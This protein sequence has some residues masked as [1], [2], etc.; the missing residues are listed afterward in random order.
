MVIADRLKTKVVTSFSS[1]TISRFLQISLLFW[2]AFFAQIQVK[3][4]I[5]EIEQ[6][7]SEFNNGNYPKAIK[8]AEENIEQAVKTNDDLSV[9]KRLDIIASSQISLGKYEEAEVT[10]NNSLR[11]F[12]EKESISI[13]KA[14]IFIR[15]A[16][17]NR[18]QRK[19]AEAFDYSRKA[20]AAAPNNRQIQA[21]HYLNIGRILFAS[22]YDI[23]AV[24]WLEKAEK[25]FEVEK[26]SSAKLDTYRF[27]TLAWHSKLNY[28]TALKYAEKWILSAQNSRFKYQYRQALFESVMVL[29]ESEQNEKAHLYLE[30]GLKLSEEQNDDYQACKFLTSLLLHSL[31]KG[32]ISVASGYLNKLEKNNFENQFSFEIKLGKAV[33]SA[34]SGEIETSKKLF[35]ELEKQ[36]NTSDFILLYWKI[37]VAEINSDWQ[38]AIKLNRE[39]LKVTEENN[40][41]DGLPKIYLNF[42]RAYYRL[43]KS[44]MS[45]EYLEKSLAYIEEIRKSENP[46]LSLALF[47][48]YHN[49]Y[50]LLAQIKSANPQESFELADF[51]KAR[52][53][54]DKINN[55]ANKTEMVIQPEIRQKLEEL[56]I[57]FIN[58]QSLAGEVE[59]NEKLITSQAAELNLAKPDLSELSKISDLDETAVVSY[60][61]TLDKKLKAFVW[62]KNLPLKSV[63]LTISEAEVESYAVITHQ[64][65]KNFIFFKKDGKEIYDKLLKPLNI[66]AK[67]L[68]IVPDKSL[69]KIPFQALSPDGEKYLIEEKLIS[70]APSVSILLKQIQNPKPNRQSLKAFAN[71]T[72]EN[73][74]LQYA[75]AEATGVA[76]I[77]GSNPLLNTTTADFKQNSEKVDILH[78]S[79]HAQVDNEQPL[80]SFLGFRKSGNDDGRLTVEDV[81]GIKLKRGSLV[82]LASCDTNNVL[83]GE[84]LLSLAWGMIGSGAT[85]VISAQWEANDKS[86]SVFTTSFYKNYKKGSSPVEAMQSASLELIKNKSNNMHEP[87]YWAD[88]G[89]NGD[90]R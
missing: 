62:E 12:S 2:L 35:E 78:F 10:L 79:M 31:D 17:L 34:F 80:N 83:N 4:E 3:G 49:A 25:L 26:E 69:W 27:L 90:F 84:G 19:F 55:S 47:E 76:E 77:Y 23:S 81:L 41:R 24:I 48:T 51:L 54:K 53:L 60:F 33:I 57:K 50:R 5:S 44:Q 86:T 22:G 87:Y 56:S 72:Y 8:L 73:R 40:F 82:F 64:K 38:K 29:S 85:T 39:L 18:S 65:I 9:F 16:W 43:E 67:H 45:L 59:S 14:Q 61:F 74:F 36:E 88:F 75:D 42:A 13:Q 58:D 70:Y 1:Q 37:I 21:E 28:Q 52:L 68:I 71:S 89:L 30:K 66:S 20:V 6:A 15:F 63:N 46:N 11:K 7:Q 32:D